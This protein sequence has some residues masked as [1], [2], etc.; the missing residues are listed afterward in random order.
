MASA[1]DMEEVQEKEAPA[2]EAAAE[3]ETEVEEEGMT[4]SL[5]HDHYRRLF[6]K[7]L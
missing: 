1:Q 7:Y 5:N 4:I 6:V 2:V 3:E